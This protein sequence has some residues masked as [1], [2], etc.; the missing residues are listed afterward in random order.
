MKI[1]Q[2]KTETLS[3]QA[4]E[5]IKDLI[6]KNELLPGQSIAIN[7][8]AKSLGISP[9]PVRE[10]F[11]KLAAEGFLE[12]EPHKKI[13][14]A[15]ITEDDIHRVYG[16]RKLLEPPA[17]SLA[18]EAVSNDSHLKVLLESIQKSAQ[19]ICAA[20]SD[21]INKNDYL[22][23]DAKL[24]ETF[25]HAVDP[26]YREVLEFVGI[27]SLRIRT[28]AEAA[29]RLRSDVLMVTVTKEHLQII[30]AILKENAED[31]KSIVHRHLEKSEA[32]TLQAVQVLLT[33]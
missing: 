27:R 31:A 17:A 24:H 23:I 1:Q 6:I 30:Q 9:T 12:G 28:F 7:T 16:V 32:R 4:Y 13:H 2:L 3:S 21:R 10:A 29:S 14:V 18:A 25:L 8:I 33:A 20:A 11:A 19:K 5:A 15:K 26:F 22:N